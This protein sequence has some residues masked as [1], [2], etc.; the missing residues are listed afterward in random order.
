MTVSIS[1]ST[2]GDRALILCAAASTLFYSYVHTCDDTRTSVVEIGRG[3]IE[4]CSYARYRTGID[5]ASRRSVEEQRS[6]EAPALPQAR[7]R[8]HKKASTHSGRHVVVLVCE[9][10][11]RKIKAK[12]LHDEFPDIVEVYKCRF[13]ISS[14]IMSE[15]RRTGRNER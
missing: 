8:D 4:H 5:P 7:A 12:R 3:A 6:R 15:E 2:I 14:A 13:D 10:R 1:G 9:R 11:T